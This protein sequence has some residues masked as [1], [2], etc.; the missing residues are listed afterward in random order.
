MRKI[1]LLIRK[2]LPALII[3][4]ALGSFNQLQAQDKY[5]FA[6]FDNE[7]KDVDTYYLF[8][9]DPVKNWFKMS[10][11][12]R[13]DWETEFRIS[14]NSQA[15]DKVMANYDKPVPD[16]GSYENYTSLSKCREA[17]QDHIFKF[18]KD[19]EKYGKPVKVIYINLKQ[20]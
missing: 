15:G 4:M 13:E 17:I 5:S 10:E 18:K 8:I 14:A 3:F 2:Y 9:S 1:L 12:Q 20:F 11:S 19:L 7:F 6:T 16:G